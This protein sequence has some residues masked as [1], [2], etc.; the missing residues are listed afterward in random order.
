MK[1]PV[2][3]R[4][5]LYEEIAAEFERR[6]VEGD[7]APGDQLPSERKIMEEFGTGRPAVREALFALS[8]M[9]LVAQNSGEP[10]RVTKPTAEVLIGEL[11]G[12][13]RALLADPEG[14]RQFQDA[15]MLFETALVREAAAN[16]TDDDVK[17]LSEALEANKRAVGTP[18]NFE[19]TDVEFHYVLA[20][21]AQNQILTA[22]HEGLLEWLSEQRAISNAYPGATAAAIAAHTRIFEAIAARDAD[23]AE[24]AMRDHLSEVARTYWEVKAG[25]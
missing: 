3:R 13:A 14:V 15:R 9:G 17:M 21:I 12:A 4:R 25:R 2:I 23:A 18:L 7:Y 6:I 16:A 22:L 10:A 8:K 24:A 20:V 5:K 11:S 1:R 19:R